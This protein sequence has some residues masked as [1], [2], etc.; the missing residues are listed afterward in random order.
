MPRSTPEHRTELL[1]QWSALGLELG[2]GETP[3]WHREGRRLLRQ[4]SWWPRHYH[5]TRHLGA[6]LRHFEAIRSFLAEPHAVALALWYHDA[7]YWPW[8]KD[9]EQRSAEQAARFLRRMPC[10]QG[11]EAPVRTL[12][13]ATCH[14]APAPTPDAQW[15]VDIDLAILG[16]PPG[17]YARFEQEVRREYRFAPWPRYVEG[18]CAVLQSFLARPRIYATDWFHQRL[19]AQARHNMQAAIESLRSRDGRFA[20]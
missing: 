9:N 4:W 8:R 7:V 16:Q 15:L 20:A 14:H 6:C 1:A 18:R 3:A 2:A 10:T 13:M 17:T 12:V 11:L 5:D 19:E